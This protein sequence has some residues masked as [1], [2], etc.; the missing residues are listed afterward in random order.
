MRDYMSCN[1]EACDMCVTEGSSTNTLSADPYNHQYL[2]MDAEVL[3]NQ[4]DLLQQEIPP[5]CNVIILQSVLTEVR[6]RSLPAFN[7]LGNLLRN[8]T[9]RFVFFANQNFE[10]TYG[11]IT[12]NA[13]MCSGP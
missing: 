3:V 9:K 1:S 6:K 11:A 10:H 12:M 5:L 2:I 13:V 4:S 8:T 7:Q